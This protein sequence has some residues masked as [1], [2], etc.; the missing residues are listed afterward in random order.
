MAVT[1]KCRSLQSAVSFAV[2]AVLGFVVLIAIAYWIGA[3]DVRAQQ[4]ADPL[5]A[6]RAKFARPAFVPTPADNLPTAAK[7]AL[8]KRLF[9]DPE[10]SSTGTIA[11]ATCHDAK[12]AFTDGEPTGKGVTGKPLARHTP[13]LWNV[14]WSP[15]LMW[16]GRASSLE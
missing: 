2:G 15:L 8:G 11:C 1:D 7:V 10:L 9:E 12:L 4:P 5:A 14:A 13:T 3:Q 6:L 16:D